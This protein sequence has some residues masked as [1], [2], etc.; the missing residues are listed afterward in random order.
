MCQV[1]TCSNL[2][3]WEKEALGKFAT[4]LKHIATMELHAQDTIWLV[5][6]MLTNSLV[7]I[8]F[9]EM[10]MTPNDGRCSM[11]TCTISSH[12]NLSFGRQFVTVG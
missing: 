6:G 3:F 10:N 1:Q 4:N 7:E 5:L 12:H 2:G 11:F 9:A 8:V